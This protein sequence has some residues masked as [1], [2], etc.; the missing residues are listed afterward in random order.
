MIKNHVKIAWRNILR[1]KGYALI[2]IGGLALGMAVSV[3]ILV[4][5]QFELGVDRFYPDTE[6]IY[7]VWR[8]SENQGKLTSWD[9]TPALYA[10]TLKEEYPEVEETTRVTRWD[11]QMFSVGA[12]SFYEESSFVDPAF[13]KI[14]PFDVV[15]GDPVT[16]LEDPNAI[17]L[18]ESVAA[19]LFPGEDAIGKMVVIEKRLDLMVKSVIRD[20]PENTNFRYTVFLSFK[21]LEAMGWADPYWGNNAYR[22]FV[23]LREGS[24]LQAFND[25]FSGFTSAHMDTNSITDFLFPMA[26]LHLHSTFENGVSVGG[27][28]ELIRL[29]GIVAI[30]ILL[31][32]C[33]N[34]INLNTA[35]SE[36]RAK[37]VGVRKVS[38]AS[39]AMLIS[40]FLIEA[41]LIVFFAATIAVLIVSLSLPSFR[42]LIGKDLQNPLSQPYFWILSTGLVLVVGLLSGSY[43][44]FL[45]SAFSPSM[46]FKTT[47]TYK[48][49]W[50]NPREVLVVVLFSIVAILISSLWIIRDQMQFVQNRD[51]GLNKANLIFHPITDPIRKRKL[52]F[53]EALLGLNEVSDVSYTFSPLTE[54][55]SSSDAM[56]WQGKE[57][58]DRTNISRM[59][60]DAGLV[61]T[62][63]MEL[64]AGRDID[65]YS[66]PNDSNAVII[67][68]KAME[69]MGFE[70]PLGQVIQDGDLSFVVVGV[71]K[72]FI[73]A[74][75]FQEVRPVVV[76]GPKRNLHYIHIRINPEADFGR[77][78]ENLA[79]VF[80]TFN[81]DAPFEYSFVDQVHE[82]KF[83]N[84]RRTSRLMGIFTGLAVVISCMGL[85]GLAAFMAAKRS[86]EISVRKVLGAS[87]LG[88]VGLI[89]SAFTRLVL[90][91]V[92]IG[93]PVTWYFMNAWLAG[94]AYRTVID[95]KIFLWTAIAALLLAFVTVSSQAIKAALVNPANL[96]KNE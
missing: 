71:V 77:A 88:L 70:E 36:T 85:L 5:V 8:N 59:G 14:F 46:V 20:L 41:M 18:T 34:F 32:A 7:A 40:Q 89:A 44:A 93:I 47:L 91:G 10:P 28:I 61:K 79:G 38:G 6:R 67:N 31:I 25:K 73:M 35:K 24:D 62:A 87:V 57:V 90:I 39:R 84:Q 74:S 82:R 69:V 76:F 83:E 37:E 54:I 75:P 50:V 78:M 43:P 15:S 96:L 27:K 33:I 51:L 49:A 65:V 3:L 55:H 66:F 95:W 4:W 63:G 23:L 11:P 48:R 52:P 2:N 80:H 58:E 45:L 19:K 13:F 60:S 72:D 53:R 22:T 86:K 17:V 1:S 12:N 56:S 42:D 94:F 16:A 21:K 30:V 26:K 64:L 9:D 92:V 81:P 68:E 29:F